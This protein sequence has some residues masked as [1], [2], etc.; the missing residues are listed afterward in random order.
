MSRIPP[1]LA[2][3]LVLAVVSTAAPPPS[4]EDAA[5]RAVQFVDD[6]EG[7]AAGDDGAIW[8]SIDG[9]QSWERQKSGTRATLTGIHFLTPYT[10]FV[11]GR[12]ELPGDLGSSGVLLATTDGGITWNELAS[13][14]LPGLNAVKFFDEK[15]GLVCGDGCGAY[16]GG[17]FSTSDGGQSW[18]PIVG[19]LGG[20]WLAMESKNAKHAILVGMWGRTANLHDGELVPTGLT[21]PGGRRIRAV[22]SQ[23]TTVF[24]V[25]DGGLVLVHRDYPNGSW[26]NVELPLPDA[27][28]SVCDFHTLSMVGER[29]WIGGRPGSIVLFS[30]DAGTT[31]TIQK[32]DSRVPLNAIQMLDAKTGWAVGEFGTVLTTTD[33]G[34]SWKH[35]RGKLHAAV[36]GAHASPKSV[37]LTMYPVIGAAEGY[38]TATMSFTCADASADPRRSTDPIRLSAAMRLAGG[39]AA[40]TLWAF[41]LPGHCDGLTADQLRGYWDRLHDGKAAD[42]LV[43]QMTLAIRMWRPEVIVTDSTLPDAPAAEQLLLATA[44]EAFQRAAEPTAYPEQI[45]TLGLKP[46]TVKKLYGNNRRAAKPEFFNDAQ[47]R[48]ELADTPRA[49][50]FAPAALLQSNCDPR[51]QLIAHRVE[52]SEQHNELM[53]GTALAYGGMARR[54]KATDVWT[55]TLEYLEQRKKAALERLQGL[56]E[57]NRGQAVRNPSPTEQWEI[58]KQ[59]VSVFS[60]TD[61]AEVVIESA[62]RTLVPSASQWALARELYSHAVEHYPTQPAT[63]PA[64]RWLARYH[65]SSETLRRIELGQMTSLRAT[66]FYELPKGEIQ[67]VS[68]SE[69]TVAKFRSSEALRGWFSTGPDLEARLFAVNPLLSREPSEQLA[70]HAARMKLGLTADAEKALAVYCTRISRTAT[71]GANPWFDAVAAELHMLNPKLMPANPKPVAACVKVSA[72]P[73]LDGKLDD[74]IW[75]G[76][77]ELMLKDGSHELQGSHATIARMAF[78]DEYLYLGVTCQHPNGEQVPPAETRKHD[79]DVAPHDRVELMLDM[80]RDYATYYRL[81]IDHRGCTAEDCWGDSS[82]NPK[83]FVAVNP[84]ATGWT[85][86]VAIPLAELTGRRPTDKHSWA[87]NLTRVLPGRGVLA[88]NGPA[89]GTPRPEAMGLLE[90]RGK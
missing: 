78:D 35:L 64:Y 43:R 26:T 59:R 62:E 23:G 21:V 49:M 17:I 31:W 15:N 83:W 19:P 63:L 29:V 11:V 87:F 71:P 66:E 12:T 79:D 56:N 34:T 47:F 25:G 81:R 3:I 67:Q 6:R 42:Q 14:V 73:I 74:D 39:A 58:A 48:P 55:F 2:L 36:L 13:G 40:E 8:H 41:P 38:L 50:A 85:A 84:T 61:A 28:R 60:P 89:D 57:P 7:W 16:P 54:A 88:W 77:M 18:R 45:E 46:H 22:K 82:W 24:A 30:P 9:G 76:T 27:A 70:F 69:A 10:G 1:T 52:G 37:P 72:R 68:H 20:S 90:F 86:E 75:K 5:L 51:L 80:D 32:T 44:Q 53:E 33:G 65:A 4:Y